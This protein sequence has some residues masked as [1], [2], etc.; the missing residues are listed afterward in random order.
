MVVVNRMRLGALVLGA[1]AAT[2]VSARAGAEPRLPTE[3]R[4]LGQVQRLNEELARSSERFD[5]ARWRLGVAER[6]A[7]AARRSIARAKRQLRA[8]RR[9]VS[10]QLVSLYEEGDGPGL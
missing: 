2:V 10:A 5:G 6:D 8:A 7:R 3:Q 9:R 4:A 1:V